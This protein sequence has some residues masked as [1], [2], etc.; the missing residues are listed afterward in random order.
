MNISEMYQ[1]LTG[2]VSQYMKDNADN[3]REYPRYP[4]SSL[5]GLWEQLEPLG[6]H[7]LGGGHFSVAVYHKQFPKVAIKLGF[8]RMTQELHTQPFAEHIKVALVSLS[9]TK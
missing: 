3:I 6:F 7:V 8:V 1:L 4:S 9:S 5:R 2:S